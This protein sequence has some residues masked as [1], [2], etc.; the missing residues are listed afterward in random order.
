MPGGGTFRGLGMF[1]ALSFDEGRTWPVKKLITPGGPARKM[2]G[3]GNTHEFIM[4]DTHAE[5]KGYLAATQTPDRVIH[6]ISSAL[7][8]RFNLAWVRAPMPPA[9]APK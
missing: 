6:L 5:P 9:T 1:A 7:H 2:D 3:L 8:Y 4:D